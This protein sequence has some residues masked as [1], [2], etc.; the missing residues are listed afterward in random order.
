MV[1]S[2]K[3]AVVAAL[4]TL[5]LAAGPRLA[6]AADATTCAGCHGPDGVST[7]PTIPII[8]GLS[9]KYLKASFENYKAK[10]R[11]CVAVEVKTGDKKGTKTDMCQVANALSD[12]DMDQLA[13]LFAG[14]PFV[15][16]EQK[17]DA[18]LAAHG[19]EL[20]QLYCDKC[21]TN[22]GKKAAD[23]KGILAGQWIPY[24]VNALD[25][26]KSGTRAVPVKMKPSI[27]DLDKAD[28]EALANYFASKK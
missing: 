2:F 25:E 5:G 22:N 7:E 12:A 14:K 10:R 6:A 18:A 4:V 16:A 28:F 15:P 26:F 1:K 23:D 21:H 9:A 17:V 8:A 13:E 20:Q 11:P 19:D 3:I 27:K 24:L